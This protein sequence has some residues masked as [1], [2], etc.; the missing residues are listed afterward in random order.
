MLQWQFDTD[1]GV[2]VDNAWTL[3]SLT[4]DGT[5]PVLYVNGTKP[6]QA[7]S[8]TT[9]KTAWF[10]VATNLD[11]GFLGKLS[12][13]GSSNQL[14]FTGDTGEVWAHNYALSADEEL[15]LHSRTRGRYD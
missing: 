6:L 4:Q 10:A 9:D 5:E 13:V 12:N 14:P 3:L 1:A 8:T 2:M 7:F 11:N 15:Y